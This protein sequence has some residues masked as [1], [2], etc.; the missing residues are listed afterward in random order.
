MLFVTL[1]V[2]SGK[3][4]RNLIGFSIDL[5]ALFRFAEYTTESLLYLLFWGSMV[6]VASAAILYNGPE[7]VDWPKL[8]SRY[9]N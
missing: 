9:V 7:F 4:K 6:G 2:P 1:L 5:I 3:S 8:V